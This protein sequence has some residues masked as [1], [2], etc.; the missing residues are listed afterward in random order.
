MAKPIPPLP[1]GGGMGF[2][3]PPYASKTHGR[4]KRMVN[5][6][7]AHDMSLMQRENRDGL[8]RITRGGTALDGN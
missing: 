3:I 1:P 7:L 5:L 8:D 6:C 2:A 4:N